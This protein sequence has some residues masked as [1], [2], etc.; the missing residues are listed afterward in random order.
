MPGTSSCYTCWCI[1]GN[2]MQQFPTGGK[3]CVRH[4][5]LVLF[6]SSFTPNPK[7]FPYE[8]VESKRKG[9]GVVGV[10]NVFKADATCAA[11]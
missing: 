10:K 9:M 4:M 11:W 3:C 5:Q 1:Y 2:A 6:V 8:K 7:H